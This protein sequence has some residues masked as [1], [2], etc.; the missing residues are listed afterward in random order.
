MPEP[1]SSSAAG[2]S[3]LI[4]ANPGLLG[5][6][7][8]AILLG[9][10]PAKTRKEGFIRFFAAIS[11]SALFGETAVLAV[12]HYLPFLSAD[13]TRAGVYAMVGAPVYLILGWVIRQFDEDRDNRLLKILRG[14]KE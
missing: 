11:C 7:G 13:Q 8:G 3:W 10:I 14:S 12:F 1:S 5:A 2:I 9:A 4:K 6:I